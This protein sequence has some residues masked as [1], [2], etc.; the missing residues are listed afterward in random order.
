MKVTVSRKLAAVL[1]A[2]AALVALSPV[3]TANAAEQCDF[4]FSTNKFS[5]SGADAVRKPSD[6]I[7]ARLFTGTNFT[8]A[9][10]TVWTPR[11]CPKNDKVDH[12]L[13]LNGSKWTRNIGSVQAWSTCWVWLY[14]SDGNRSGPFDSNMSDVTFAG[15]HTTTVGLS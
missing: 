15:R 1:A 6:V 3:A 9:T 7:G 13:A 8:G 10:L 2:V 11:P 12:F 5:C 4:S 14:Q